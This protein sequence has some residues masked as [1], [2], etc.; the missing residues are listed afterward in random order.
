[1]SVNRSRVITAPNLEVSCCKPVAQSLRLKDDSC[2]PRYLGAL[3]DARLNLPK[4]PS[5]FETASEA[6]FPDRDFNR[7]PQAGPLFHTICA[8]FFP[9]RSFDFGLLRNTKKHP[10]VPTRKKNTGQ[11]LLFPDPGSFV[12]TVHQKSPG[13]I[14]NLP[15][16]TRSVTQPTPVVL[17]GS[18][19][20]DFEGLKHAY[21]E[22]RDL[23]CEILSPSN[24]IAVNE[25]DGF[26]FMKGEESQ[27]PDAVEAQHLDAIQKSQF[28]W[29]HAPSGYVGSSG[30]LEVGFAHAVGVPVYSKEPV[31][32]PILRRFVQVVPSPLTVVNQISTGGLEVPKPA[33]S[34]FQHYYRRVAIQ[35]G[36]HS[37]GPKECLLLL[38]EEVGELAREIR[39]R[40]KIVRHGAV[41]PPTESQ[42]LADI[43]LYVVHM[44]N[45]L[46]VDLAQVVQ[47]KELIN[48]QR[49]SV[50]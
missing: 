50:R 2:D 5:W 4:I 40:E 3:D 35:R 37:E 43:F 23:N 16:G 19:R 44:A 22:L 38:V 1:M 28:M 46:D 13:P 15:I 49:A 11:I 48:M 10:T 31:N 32:D 14:S 6:K 27:K 18:Y 42:E 36:Y 12:A 24:V 7:I 8:G 30:A 21:E 17:S 45:V 34:A 26:V 20:K 9:R 25:V 33:L 39:K 41:T 47:D 29:L